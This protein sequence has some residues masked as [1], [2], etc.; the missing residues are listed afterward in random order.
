MVLG[1]RPGRG[2]GPV[3]GGSGGP[4]TPSERGRRF[5]P[6]EMMRKRPRNTDPGLLQDPPLPGVPPPGGGKHL[7]LWVL[8]TLPV[9]R[10]PEPQ[11][12]WSPRASHLH[13]GAPAV[14]PSPRARAPLPSPLGGRQQRGAAT[15]A[16]G[17]CRQGGGCR[18]D[19]EGLATPTVGFAGTCPGSFL[20]G[21]GA[22]RSVLPGRCG[23]RGCAYGAVAGDFQNGA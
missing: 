4:E 20:G 12:D 1:A 17:G 6:S 13:L 18:E 3:L 5:C 22:V 16:T 19:R 8:R 10:G 15:E 9:D 14:P 7:A 2:A 11:E 21:R 23:L